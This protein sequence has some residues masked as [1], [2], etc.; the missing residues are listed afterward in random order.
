MGAKGVLYILLI[1]SNGYLAHFHDS[2][3]KAAL[4]SIARLPS[5]SP[6]IPL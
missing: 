3:T 4:L 2:A 6:F 1:P 5:F